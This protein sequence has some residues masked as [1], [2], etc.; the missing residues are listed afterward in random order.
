MTSLVE[1]ADE[2]GLVNN[3]EYVGEAL[4]CRF[5]TVLYLFRV[6]NYRFIFCI[7]SDSLKQEIRKE[8]VHTEANGDQSV[9]K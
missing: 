2:R 1:S 4:A 9:R 3:A 5:M 6:M 8:G 7:F